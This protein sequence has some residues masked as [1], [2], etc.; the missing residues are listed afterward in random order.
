MR[1]GFWPLLVLQSVLLSLLLTWPVILDLGGRVLGHRDADTMKHVWTLWW[2]RAHL[3]REGMVLHS[4]LLNQPHGLDLWPVEPLNGLLAA[5]L[6]WIPVVATANALAIVN[7]AATGFCGGLLGWALTRCRWSAFATAFLLQTSSFALFSLHVGVGE[8][9]HLWLLPLGCWAL[10]RL[11]RQGQWRW[12][13]ATGLVLGL[14]TVACFYYGFYLSL[15]LVLLGFSALVRAERRGRLFGQLLVAALLAAAIVVPVSGAFASSYGDDFQSMYSL[16]DFVTREGLGQT[17]V[18]PVS[19]RLQPADLVV[20]RA[21]L[22]GRGF[23]D[24]EAYGGGKLLGIP[25][26]LL[27]A[28]GLTLRPRVAWAW[29]A[30]AVVGILLAMGSYLSADGAELRWSGALLRM[31]FLYVNRLFTYLAEPLNFPVRFLALSTVALAAL[32]GLTV[33]RARGAWRWAALALVLL[34]AVDVQ[35]RGLLPWPLPAFELPD[36]RVLRAM[37][38]SG[39]S[40]GGDGAVLDLAGAFRH[41]PESRLVVMASQIQHQQAIQAVP[42]DRLEFHVREGRWFAAGLQL[43]DDLGDAY[44]R[45]GAVRQGDWRGD[46]HVLRESGFDRILV[47]SLGAREPLPR[48]VRRALDT[49][50][51]EPVL[52]AD[53]LALYRIPELDPSAREADAWVREHAERARK[54]EENTLA[55]GPMPALGPHRP[56]PPPE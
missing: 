39:E 56:E 51:G 8:L 44:A 42:I 32:A 45:Q 34:N 53:T 35:L 52:A 17:V 37:D 28:A 9:Q 40:T 1:R 26:L 5:L 3:L 54:A 10:L 36:L 46:L 6:P 4:D 33:G 30:V 47:V 23:G 18:D 20:G 29:L 55:P 38:D 16:L 13:V 49:A 41:D 48:E 19:A 12:V 27:A 50:I 2:A 15:A 25:M 31:P 11:E 22:W 14:G 21:E 24:L 7:L 43:V